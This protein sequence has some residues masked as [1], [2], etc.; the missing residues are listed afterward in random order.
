MRGKGDT[1]NPPVIPEILPEESYP[2]RVPTP[3]NNYVRYIRFLS[4]YRVLI[5]YIL[6]LYSYMPVLDLI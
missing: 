2:D 3:M 5:W 6:I 1:P 4:S